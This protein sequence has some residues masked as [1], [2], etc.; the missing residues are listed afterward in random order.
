MLSN[1]LFRYGFISLS[2]FMIILTIA[3]IYPANNWA[4]T[5][6]IMAAEIPSSNHENL[7]RMLH[8][9]L[10]VGQFTAAEHPTFGQATIILENE[11]RYLELDSAFQ[12]DSGPDLFVLLHYQANPTRYQ[13]NDYIILGPLQTTSGVQ[14]YLIPEDVDI[15]PIQSAVIWCRQFNATFGFAT[16]S[17]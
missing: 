10:K 7:S 11:Q 9:P 6:N 2:S 16:F 3:F 17:E 1:K 13:P 4:T 5:A 14:R 8:M 12:T 15:T